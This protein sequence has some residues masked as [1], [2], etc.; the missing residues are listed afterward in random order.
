MNHPDTESGLS[1]KTRITTTITTM[2]VMMDTVH[3]IPATVHQV[4]GMALLK[5]QHIPPLHMKHLLLLT[6]HLHL[7]TMHLHT[8]H[9]LHL[10]V[11][12]HMTRKFN[13]F[14]AILSWVISYNNLMH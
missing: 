3:L 5:L 7:L 1:Q 6:M 11:L 10:M 13:L 12:H 4:M 9:L 14:D 8:M 2:T